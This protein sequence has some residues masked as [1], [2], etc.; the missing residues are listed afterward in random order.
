MEK[1]IQAIPFEIN[2]ADDTD[3]MGIVSGYASAFNTITSYG[4][5]F[6][7]GAFSDAVANFK[8]IKVL[9]NHN[10]DAIVG[11]PLE[12]REDANGLFVK[13][14]LLTRTPKGKEMYELV[15]AGA[16]DAFSIGFYVDEAADEI[17]D[18]NTIRKITKATVM[19]YSLVTFPANQGA[20]VLDVNS[21]PSGVVDEEVE[22]LELL[23]N[24]LL[25]LNDTILERRLELECSRLA[26]QMEL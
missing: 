4:Q 14:Q 2:S 18:G 5:Q 26:A 1:L 6:M 19:E 11:V 16:L 23:A 21:Q 13:T 17:I 7:P 22:K 8:K 15:K 12:M 3:G 25:C 10:W 20:V 9:F 24:S